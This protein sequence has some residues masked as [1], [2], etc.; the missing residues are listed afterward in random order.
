MPE[1]ETT[2]QANQPSQAPELK[3]IRTF[4][5]DVAEALA[6]QNESLVS[7]SR[8][9]HARAEAPTPT[10]SS[11]ISYLLI[12]LL[13]LALAG[14]GGYY[15]YNLYQANVTPPKVERPAGQFI[16][17]ESEAKLNISNLTRDEIFAQFNQALAEIKPTE[18]RHV[19]MSLGVGT[20]TKQASIGDILNFIS[21]NVPGSLVR[22]FE[23]APMLG[24]LGQSHFFIIKL[25]SYPN[26]FSGML[27]WE[28]SMA[29][30]LSGFFANREGLEQT[31]NNFKDIIWRNK[32]TRAL[33]SNESSTPVLLYSFYNSE[34]LIVTD[35]FT[36]LDTIIER[37]TREKLSR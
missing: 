11:S 27:A 26:A 20:T 37:L 21:A 6:K 29:T 30:D 7:L 4:Q 25:N 28:G 15:S 31:R 10:K 14:G 22:S 12:S 33:Y 8:K 5:G 18:L 34:Y 23:S 17:A 16:T 3:Q 24:A 9:E 1:G 13:L 32:D 2:P 35:Q 19:V 36:T